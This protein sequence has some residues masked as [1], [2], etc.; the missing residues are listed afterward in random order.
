MRFH[1]VARLAAT[2]AEIQRVAF[3][4]LEASGL[5]SI[6]FPTEV[7]WAFIRADGAIESGSVLIRPPVKWTMYRNAWSAASERLT[8]ITREML[9]RD[10]LPPSEAL[11]GFI[12]AVGDRDVLSDEPDFDAHWL[13][14]LAD[15]ARMSLDGRPI[16]DAEKFANQMGVILEFDEPPLHRAEADARRLALAIAQATSSRRDVRKER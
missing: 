10:G 6:G 4:D 15:A 2:P 8:G 5:G 11:K 14:M 13:G 7:G 16:G 12:D 3:V 9:D 1:R